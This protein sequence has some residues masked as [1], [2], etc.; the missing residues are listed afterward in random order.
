MHFVYVLY[1]HTNTIHTLIYKY[2]H[3]SMSFYIYAEACVHV[4]IVGCR[5]IV[6]TISKMVQDCV[7]QLWLSIVE[8][9][10]QTM[11]VKPANWL[12]INF[13]NKTSQFADIHHFQN[14]P[15]KSRIDSIHHH[16]CFNRPHTTIFCWVTV[17]VWFPFLETSHVYNIH[18]Y[19]FPS[20]SFS[21]A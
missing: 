21:D 10:G 15:N 19:I 3:A 12:I 2:M 6:T 17:T 18:A 9:T 20:L 14:K 5:P 1:T 16:P 7:H 11:P 8:I 4:P 13:T